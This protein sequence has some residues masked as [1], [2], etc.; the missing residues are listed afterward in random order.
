MSKVCLFGPSTRSPSTMPCEHGDH[1]SHAAPRSSRVAHS[2]L[3]GAFVPVFIFVSVAAAG[4]LVVSCWFLGPAAGANAGLRS[5][6]CG[7]ATGAAAGVVVPLTWLLR[8]MALAGL[9]G[10]FFIIMARALVPALRG[11][12]AGVSLPAHL[13]HKAHEAL[14]GSEAG[15][16][17]LHPKRAKEMAERLAE[18]IRIPTVS[19][20]FKPGHPKFEECTAV[21]VNQQARWLC[22]HS[23]C[24]SPNRYYAVCVLQPS[25]LR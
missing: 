23:K 11:G 4:V 14:V 3:L 6:A 20:D 2:S 12:R 10:L 9:P 22:K 17:L 24:C 1:M 8:W 7:D 15:R 16:R 25:T 13:R 21:L 5:W 19:F 18:S